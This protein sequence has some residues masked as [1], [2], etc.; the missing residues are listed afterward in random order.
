[1]KTEKR[2]VAG[3]RSETAD[4]KGV[5]LHY[6]RRRLAALRRMAYLP[7]DGTFADLDLV[8]PSLRM[9]LHCLGQIQAELRVQ[10]A[11]EAT[12]RRFDYDHRQDHHLRHKA[13]Q[14]TDFR[15]AR[16]QAKR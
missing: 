16:S 3:F 9:L 6:R 10:S 11:S 15:D 1:M 12:R 8:L 13:H 7:E 5:T 14:A 2:S 4:V